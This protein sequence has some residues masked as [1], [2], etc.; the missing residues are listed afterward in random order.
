MR[1]PLHHKDFTIDPPMLTRQEVFSGDRETDEKCD[2][3][4][5]GPRHH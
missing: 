5:D 3:S 4:S 1:A 2:P